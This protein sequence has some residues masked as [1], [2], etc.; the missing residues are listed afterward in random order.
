MKQAVPHQKENE[1][2]IISRLTDLFTEI[3]IDGDK[4]LSWEEFTSFIIKSGVE[5][6][7]PTKSMKQVL[8]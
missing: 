7:D 3:D 6:F 2:N 8:L 1:N 4:E 5:P